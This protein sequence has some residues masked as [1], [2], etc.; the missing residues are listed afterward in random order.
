M[1]QADIRDGQIWIIEP[2][3]E[4]CAGPVTR[5]EIKEPQPSLAELKKNQLILM[6]ALAKLSEATPGGI[7]AELM[8]E[9]VLAGKRTIDQVPAD[10]QKDVSGRVG[11]VSEL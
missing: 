3:G 7:S 1:A 8:A 9:L 10:I 11:I 6:E 2:K 5:P 4:W